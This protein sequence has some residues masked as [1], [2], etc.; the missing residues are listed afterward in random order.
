MARA[1]DDDPIVRQLLAD[2]RALRE[3]DRRRLATKPGTPARA[4]ATA[5]LDRMNEEVMD[6]FRRAQLPGG[7][8][9]SC[10]GSRGPSRSGP[11]GAA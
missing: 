2:L 11:D 8:R 4:R 7:R 10:K 9:P 3:L 5:A 6:R 1:F